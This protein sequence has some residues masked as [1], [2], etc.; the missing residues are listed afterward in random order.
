MTT[1]Y[2]SPHLDDVAFSCASG[3]LR[4]LDQG[5]R[6]IVATV[7]TEGKGS[8]A[9]RKEDRAALEAINAEVIH[10]G[11]LDAP[12]RLQ[13]KASFNSLVLSPTIDRKLVARIKRAL[14]E[15]EADRSYF[16]LGIGGHVDHRTVFEAR[17]RRARFYEDRPYTYAAPL[18]TLRMLELRGGRRRK[19][20]PAKLNRELQ[21]VAS[22]FAPGER[23]ACTAELAKRLATAHPRRFKLG[24][25][26]H[27]YSRSVARRAAALIAAYGSQS[28][29]FRAAA[30][31]QRE[32]EFRVATALPRD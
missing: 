22:F 19:L 16:P 23:A 21:P 29:P 28:F 11:F 14:D 13:I 7:F 2:V 27:I 25:V 17:S 6:V 24:S 32:R 12:D 15:I 31:L 5:E 1:L 8:A 20:D 30:S 4:R 10:L 9:R 18:R 26:S 3:L